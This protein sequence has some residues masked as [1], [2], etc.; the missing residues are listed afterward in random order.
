MGNRKSHS[1]PI[2]QQ[3]NKLNMGNRKN[4]K[5]ILIK[6]TTKR[7]D[8]EIYYAVQDYK[9]EKKLYA[10]DVLELF[11]LVKTEE[12]NSQYTRY[13]LKYAFD[14]LKDKLDENGVELFKTQ[15]KK[16]F[17]KTFK[18]YTER[19]YDGALQ[20]REQVMSKAFSNGEY[21]PGNMDILVLG[22]KL[23]K[24]NVQEAG[25]Y[26]DMGYKINKDTFN[27]ISPYL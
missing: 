10:E 6:G 26:D 3:S 25:R 16:V 24:D 14:T 18:N 12:R 19:R 27:R 23:P 1:I 11:S 13:A 20:T 2:I 7:V 4:T 5:T 21:I 17:G 8:T 22:F 9:K 15:F